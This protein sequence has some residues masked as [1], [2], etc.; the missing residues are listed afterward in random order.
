M[1]CLFSPPINVLWFSYGTAFRIPMF[2][3]KVLNALTVSSITAL[4]SL[5]RKGGVGALASMHTICFYQFSKINLTP[6]F[7]HDLL[8]TP[9]LI[10]WCILFF[11]ISFEKYQFCLNCPSCLTVHCAAM[12]EFLLSVLNIKCCLKVQASQVMTN[13]RL[14]NNNI[15]LHLQHCLT[16][17]WFSLGAL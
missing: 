6:S 2:I 14:Q 8:N 4:L 13:V 15:K 5:H 10:S 11:T 7:L 3:Y 1:L 9:N 16:L 12:C 17:K